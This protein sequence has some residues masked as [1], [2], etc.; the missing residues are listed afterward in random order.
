MTVTR[1]L[2]T[3]AAMMMA[4]VSPARADTLIYITDPAGETLFAEADETSPY[5]KLATY[6]ESEQILTFCGPAT[7]AAV[8][9]S[10]D[11]PRPVPQRLFPWGLFTQDAVFTPENQAVKPYPMVERDGL[12]LEQLVQFFNNL[13]VKAELHHADS[14]DVAALRELIK[15]GLAAPDTRLVANYSR[16]P[17]GQN[18]DGHISPIAAYDVETDRVLVLDVAKY[19]YPPVWMTVA[20]LHAAMNTIDSGSNKTRGIVVVTK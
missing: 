2:I 18:G 17:I 10:L 1:T 14:I 4:S 8:L 15:A 16:K 9:N 12:V 6:L 5:F 7:I 13:G 11:I 3:L 20:D 19:K